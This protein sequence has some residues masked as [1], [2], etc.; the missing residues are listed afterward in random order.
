MN[1]FWYFKVLIFRSAQHTF[2]QTK[3]YDYISRKSHNQISP[4]GHDTIKYR[5]ASETNIS[6]PL[7]SIPFS[8][9]SYSFKLESDY[10]FC[11]AVKEGVSAFRRFD[12]SRENMSYLYHTGFRRLAGS[13][14]SYNR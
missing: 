8:I 4:S 1:R 11:N 2:A 10:N 9:G 12:W 14:E 3:S 6:L 5:S 13:Y 7:R